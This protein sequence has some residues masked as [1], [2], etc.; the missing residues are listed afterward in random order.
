MAT[1]IIKHDVIWNGRR[2]RLSEPLTLVIELSEGLWCFD[3]PSLDLVGCGRSVDDAVSDFD[4]QFAFIWDEIANEDDSML[5]PRARQLKAE[6]LR[7][8]VGIESAA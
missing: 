2:F 3:C 5:L 1:T 4:G 7:L 8:V 6:L